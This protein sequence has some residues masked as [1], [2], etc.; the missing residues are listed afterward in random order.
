VACLGDYAE[1][2][3][4]N[5]GKIAAMGGGAALAQISAAALAEGD[6]DRLKVALTRAMGVL[7]RNCPTR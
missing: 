1:S 4:L 5:C 2:S 6:R 7:V 3:V